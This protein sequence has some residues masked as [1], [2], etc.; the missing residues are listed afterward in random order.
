[1]KFIFLIV[2]MLI[3]APLIAVS[4]TERTHATAVEEVLRTE[5]EQRDA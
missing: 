2:L 1:M 5:R 4:Q 3:T